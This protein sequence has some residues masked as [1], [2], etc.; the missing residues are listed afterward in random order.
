MDVNPGVKNATGAMYLRA[1]HPAYGLYVAAGNGHPEVIKVLLRVN[2]NLAAGDGDGDTA[3]AW[4]TWSGR[5]DTMNQLLS[6]G[7]DASFALAGSSSKWWMVMGLVLT[8]SKRR[9]SSSD[10]RGESWAKSI[11]YFSSCKGLEIT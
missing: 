5:R 10:S 1:N 4:A 7:A 8:T 6:S 11:I 9:C 3:L 2:V